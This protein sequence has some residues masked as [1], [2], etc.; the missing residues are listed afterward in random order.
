MYP[1]QRDAEN[2]A[3]DGAFEAVVGAKDE[4]DTAPVVAAVDS[5]EQKVGAFADV[6]V[7]AV[8]DGASVAHEALSSKCHHN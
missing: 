3:A 4:A 5:E 1:E 7:V 6:A 8:L 2:D